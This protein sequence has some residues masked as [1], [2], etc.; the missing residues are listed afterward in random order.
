MLEISHRS[1]SF[2]AILA[3]GAGTLI[4][5]LLGVYPRFI[6]ILFMQ[7]LLHLQFTTIAQN[8]LRG[9]GKTAEYILTGT[10][11]NAALKEAQKEGPT[12]VVWDGKEHW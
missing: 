4:R 9:T 6:G 8:F 12:R 10:W 11:G 7:G 5:Q 1:P 3:E 2:D